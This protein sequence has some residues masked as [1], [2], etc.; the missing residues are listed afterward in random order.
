M[1]NKSE[2]QDDNRRT[3][4]LENPGRRATLSKIGLLLAGALTLG[5][6]SSEAYGKKKTIKPFQS[7]NK[8]GYI[9]HTSRSRVAQELERGHE[10]IGQAELN[11]LVTCQTLISE[12]YINPMFLY[13][14]ANK[15]RMDEVLESI[16]L[17]IANPYDFSYEIDPDDNADNDLVIKKR[18]SSK[19]TNISSN[20]RMKISARNGCIT[21]IIDTMTDD[22]S[23]NDELRKVNISEYETDAGKIARTVSRQK[24]IINS[25]LGDQSPE[26]KAELDDN[27]KS[28]FM[29][30]NKTI[31]EHIIKVMK[32]RMFGE[33]SR[34][35]GYGS[36]DDLVK[37]EKAQRNSLNSYDDYVKNDDNWQLEVFAI[38][39]KP[40]FYRIL[41]MGDE[42]NVENNIDISLDGY[43]LHADPD[44]GEVALNSNG[45]N[46]KWQL[47]EMYYKNDSNGNPEH[48]LKS[49]YYD[50]N[51]EARAVK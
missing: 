11:R 32:T 30:L 2:K 41:L 34:N 26:A 44:T 42:Y 24:D 14:F 10:I 5:A 21:Q 3:D 48:L 28:M 33:G 23:Q 4:E 47:D 16:L 40:G 25:S 38:D 39:K 46:R 13:T 6:G 17:M 9:D 35:L 20:F 18:S 37:F 45:D 31:P 22:E 36:Y 49:K 8:S 7:Y 12:A 15:K 1:L 43:V 51:P 29:L 27:L 50:S 19:K